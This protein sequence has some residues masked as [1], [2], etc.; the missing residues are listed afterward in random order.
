[1]LTE[2]TT[3]VF[4]LHNF[5]GLAAL[6]AVFAVSLWLTHVDILR[7]ETRLPDP[8]KVSCVKFVGREFTDREDIDNIL[9]LQADALEHRA[10]ESGTYVWVD[11]EWVRYID[12]N[13]DRIIEDDPNNRYTYVDRVSLTYELESGKT[14]ARYYNIW[15]DTEYVDSEAGRIAESY[16]NQ[17]DTINYRTVTIDDVEHKRLDLV[18]E[19]VQAI[20]VDFME[21]NGL[22]QE[23][24]RKALAKDARSLIAAIK[25]DCAEGNMPRIMST[26]AVPSGWRMNTRTPAMTIIRKSGSLFP[27]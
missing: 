11:G 17:W 6:A 25:A 13:A 5:C 19:N 4:N 9:R 12:T 3:R 7:I 16:M 20:Y 26:T 21:E 27:V 24:L 22:D 14:I 8:E 15:T 23:E 10:E 2:H 1:M 18:L